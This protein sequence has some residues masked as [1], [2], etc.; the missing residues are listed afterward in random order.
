MQT[1]PKREPR[2][3][4][5]HHRGQEARSSGASLPAGR[6]RRLR[7]SPCTGPVTT[8]WQPG[9][10]SEARWEPV[11]RV[12][13][14][15]FITGHRCACR[16]PA[17]LRRLKGHWFLLRAHPL[18]AQR[19]VGRAE[20]LGGRGQRGFLAPSPTRGSAPQISRTRA[21]E[22][23]RA[24]WLPPLPALLPSRAERQTSGCSVDQGQG[25]H[26]S[27]FIHFYLFIYL[28]ISDG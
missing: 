24:A 11:S 16:S 8:P 17:M 4:R 3:R 13:R 22:A 10:R 23:A 15:H 6:G 1:L 25:W 7:A 21:A 19:G 26:V 12:S 2:L 28:F 18:A 5:R 27:V 20:G 14:C 9:S